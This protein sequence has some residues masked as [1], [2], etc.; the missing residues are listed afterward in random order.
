MLEVDFSLLF[1][2]TDFALN[3]CMIKKSRTLLDRPILM[4]LLM[5]GALFGQTS[6]AGPLNEKFLG[7][8]SYIPVVTQKLEKPTLVYADVPQE[9]LSVTDRSFLL[10]KWGWAVRTVNEPASAYL[11]EFRTHSASFYGGNGMNGNIGDGRT[12]VA[13]DENFKGIGPTGMVNPHTEE[14]HNSGTLK[15]DHAVL[16]AVWSKLLDLE[17]P[18][19]ANRVRGILGTNTIEDRDGHPGLRVL[20]VRDDFLRPA[21]F[22]TNE[23]SAKVKRTKADNERVRL[24]ILNLP[25]ALPQAANAVIP[26]NRTTKLNFGLHEFIDRFAIQTAY[27]WAHSMYHGAM[28]PSNVTLAG[29]AADFGT[30]QAL[31]GYPSVQLLCDCAPN[32]DFAEELQVLKEFHEALAAHAPVTWQSA[33]GTFSDWTERFKKS[34][35]QQAEKEMLLLSGAFPELIDILEK[36]SEARNLSQTLLQIAKA[37]NEDILQTWIKPLTFES[38]TYSLPQILETLAKTKQN[39]SDLLQALQS[40]MADPSM[41]SHLVK[42]YLEYYKKMNMLSL[43]QGINTEDA[44]TYR[45]EAVKIRNQ[46][47]TELFR[48]PKLQKQLNAV[49]EKYTKTGDATVIRR[50][51]EQKVNI[52]RRNFKDAAPFTVVSQQSLDENTGRNTRKVYDA[53]LGRFTMITNIEI[54]PLETSLRQEIGIPPGRRCEGAFLAN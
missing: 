43:K 32:G 47:M 12:S 41:R 10:N 24:A 39:E 17:L 23:T 11:Q 51:I 30:F 20:I 29:G 16:E 13:G 31:G 44:Q 42:S 22:I 26:I 25:E 7:P 8:Q 14:G 40:E 50:F 54:T 49:V 45:L 6:L 27:T 34:Y 38:G 4:T 15:I 18:Y 2:G 5:V 53:K 48:T 1:Y 19:G 33:I 36:T 37:G 35:H 28:S 52:S 9:K 3:L 46:K 21:H